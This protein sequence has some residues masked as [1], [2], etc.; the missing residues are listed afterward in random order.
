MTVPC[1][2]AKRGPARDGQNDLFELVSGVRKE[3]E[4]M[5]LGKILIW[6]L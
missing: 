1:Q 5:D 4:F 3:G 2:R 6:R